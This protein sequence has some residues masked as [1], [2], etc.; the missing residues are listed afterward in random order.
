MPIPVTRV[1]FQQVLS[2]GTNTSQVLELLQ[3]ARTETRTLRVYRWR[4]STATSAQ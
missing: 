2:I 4:F 1:G 3:L